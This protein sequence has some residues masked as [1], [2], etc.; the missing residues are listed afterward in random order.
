MYID[1]V[2][3]SWQLVIAMEKLDIFQ[4]ISLIVNLNIRST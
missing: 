1:F 4:G 3:F 2:E